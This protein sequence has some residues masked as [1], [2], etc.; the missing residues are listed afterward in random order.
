MF[1][2]EFYL[3]EICL[4][5]NIIILYSS[6]PSST[7][8]LKARSDGAPDNTAV[9]QAGS[10]KSNKTNASSWIQVKP[11][12]DVKSNT[13]YLSPYP[14]EISQD[15]VHVPILPHTKQSNLHIRLVP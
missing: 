11:R 1:E 15:F 9:L 14:H 8:C 13:D 10:P 2:F 7:T 12:N 4:L 5:F 6:A 3:N